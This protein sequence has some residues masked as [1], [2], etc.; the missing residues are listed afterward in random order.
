MT[1]LQ[2]VSEIDS[3]IVIKVSLRQAWYDPRLQWDPAE[4]EGLKSITVDPTLSQT[5]WTPDI[6]CTTLSGKVDFPDLDMSRIVVYHDGLCFWN[7]PGNLDLTARF[8]IHDFPYD[9][10]KISITMEA[11]L[12]PTDKQVFVPWTLHDTGSFYL[13]FYYMEHLQWDVGSL[14]Y[15]IYQQEY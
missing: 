2:T 4:H 3:N 15:E 13:N 9:M 11:W 1:A 7:R 5:I 8:N 10:Q 12:S 14:E 6:S